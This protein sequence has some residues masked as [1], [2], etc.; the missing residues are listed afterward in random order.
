MGKFVGIQKYQQK[1][2][3]YYYQ[4]FTE[5]LG[6]ANFFIE[7]D[8]SIKRVNIYK[9]RACRIYACNID[10]NNLKQKLDCKA[11]GINQLVVT[12]LFTPIYKALQNN[13]FPMI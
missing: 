1:N 12:Y 7:I 6:G 11:N 9:D 13:E 3:L 8:P 2:N 10:F 4:V 5:D